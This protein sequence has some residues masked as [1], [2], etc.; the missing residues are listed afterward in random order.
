M[1]GTLF[2]RYS[3]LN[4]TVQCG[5]EHLLQTNQSTE[6]MS[7][8]TQRPIRAQ[9]ACHETNADQMDYRVTEILRIAITRHTLVPSRILQKYFKSEF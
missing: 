4:Q 9:N 8:V 7:R 6:R 2:F 5:A 1:S 3:I